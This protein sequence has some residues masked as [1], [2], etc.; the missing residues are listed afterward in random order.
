MESMFISQVFFSTFAVQIHFFISYTIIISIDLHYVVYNLRMSRIR[1][2]E[3][4]QTISK[5]LFGNAR[6]R[7]VRIMRNK[8]S[9]AR[10][11]NGPNVVYLLIHFP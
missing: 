9:M 4:E 3:F 1:S 10:C 11:L 8:I 2:I 5:I 7:N 6:K